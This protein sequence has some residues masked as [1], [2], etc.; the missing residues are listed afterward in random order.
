MSHQM[1]FFYFF[2]IKKRVMGDGF[3]S[4]MYQPFLITTT[5]G[6]GV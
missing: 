4:P 3:L 2:Y 6:T 1:T 5:C